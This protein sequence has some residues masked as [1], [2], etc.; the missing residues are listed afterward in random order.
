MSA[1]GTRPAFFA[2]G[3]QVVVRS[4]PR[5]RDL[6]GEVG[7]ITSRGVRLATG[8]Y[9]YGVVL[10]TGQPLCCEAD[11]LEAVEDAS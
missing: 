6:E 9:Y 3:D 1:V 7:E 11:W 2:D 4:H 8:A 5:N 10:S